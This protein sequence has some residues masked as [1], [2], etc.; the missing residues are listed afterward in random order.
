MATRKRKSSSSAATSGW[1]HQLRQQLSG[2]AATFVWGAIFGTAVLTLPL[3]SVGTLDFSSWPP[4]FTLNANAPQW[5][6][7]LRDLIAPQDASRSKTTARGRNNINPSNIPAGSFK[8]CADQF[9]AQRPVQTAHI[10]TQW[11]PLALCS[12]AFAVLH[13]GLTKTPLLV[14]E[15]LDRTRLQHAAQQERTDQFYA[16]ARIRANQRAELADYQG[17][18]YDRGH[19][20]A[21]ANQPSAVAMVD[22]F[23]LSNMVPQ[24][25]AHN[26]DVWAR[27][28]SDVRQ[29]AQRAPG[30]VYVFSGPL[31]ENKNTRKIGPGK[32]WVPSHLFKLMYDETKQIA[33]AYVLPNRADASLA[34]PLDY[35][36]FVQRTHWDVLHGLPIKGTLR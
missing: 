32:V 1:L 16:D 36:S 25:S 23:A 33:W 22:S 10:S 29:Y 15:R 35:A 19:L 18:G 6:V 7:Q 13:S 30:N 20:S 14:V 21:A 8:A 11:E 17:S 5:L 3:G 24:N 27:L 2:R 12:Q 4:G 34:R 31:H 26:R 9:P 28:E